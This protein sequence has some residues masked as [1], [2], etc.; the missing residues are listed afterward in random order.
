MRKVSKKLL[1]STVSKENV[2][3][4]SDACVKW[5]YLLACILGREPK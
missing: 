1:R 3:S 4:R 5:K 2:L